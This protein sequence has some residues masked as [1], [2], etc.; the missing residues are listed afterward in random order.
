MKKIFIALFA[1]AIVFAMAGCS[2]NGANDLQ[3]NPQSVVGGFSQ[4]R[5][6]T[7]DEEELFKKAV[8]GL[9]SV[10]Y[11]PLKVSTQVVSGTNYKFLCEGVTAD[12]SMTK[13][14]YYITVYLAPG[15][16]AEPEVTSIESA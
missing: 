15:Q 10:Q 4:E 14:Q 7:Q 8:A 2:A 13:S 1:L 9:V 11:T 5:E 12:A 6:L 16:D 3:S